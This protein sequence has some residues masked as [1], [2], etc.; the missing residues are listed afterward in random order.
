MSIRKDR[1]LIFLYGLLFTF[2][3]FFATNSENYLK[4]FGETEQIKD[5]LYFISG[6][7]IVVLLIYFSRKKITNFTINK[8]SIMEMIEKYSVKDNII[9][10]TGIFSFFII[11]NELL[12]MFIGI[13]SEISGLQS[14]IFA[15]SCCIVTL[16]SFVIYISKSYFYERERN[17]LV[18]NNE[19]VYEMVL[20][21]HTKRLFSLGCIIAIL[22]IFTFLSTIVNEMELYSLNNDYEG[23]KI[24]FLWFLNEL[25]S[26]L[27]I[28]FGFIIKKIFSYFNLVKIKSKEADIFNIPLE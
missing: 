1:I 20:S 19:K 4:E 8:L 21:H 6:F 11:L 9:V 23:K 22:F 28:I 16:V 3:L 18:K 26:V 15:I 14:T 27:S 13:N 10:S 5:I 17:E 25:V 24:N 7:F 12:F 2:L